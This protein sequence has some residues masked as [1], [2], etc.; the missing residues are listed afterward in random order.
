MRAVWVVSTTGSG[1]SSMM[2]GFS[3]SLST[4]SRDL[5]GSP[6]WMGSGDLG[7]VL[8]A[9]TRVSD[10][11]RYLPSLM[12]DMEYMTTKKANSRVMKSA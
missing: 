5:R 12:E 2:S 11:T 4:G 7:G 6:S 10:S 1:L 9:S 3:I 8:K